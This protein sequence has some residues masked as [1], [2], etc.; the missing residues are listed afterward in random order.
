M[1]KKIR[2]IIE[3]D[4]EKCTGCGQCIIA[5]AEGALAIVDGKARLVGEIY[6][7]GLGACI[8]SCPEDAL[9]IVER[10]AE[11]FDENAVEELKRSSQPQQMACGCPSSMT[12]TLTPA[13]SPTS[14]PH[15]STLGHWPVKLALL[16]P[17]APFLQ[18]ADLVLLADC[19]AAAYPGLH[20]DILPGRAIAMACPK[21]D[22]LE[23]HIERLAA[24]L[25]EARP[26]SL[27]IV[28]ME[29]PCCSGL[30][31][32]AN[33]AMTRAGVELPVEIIRIGIDGKV[34]ETSHQGPVSAPGACPSCG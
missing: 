2:K 23:P 21:L 32:A 12:R 9:R 19:A 20:A 30:I 6:C 8:G 16:T 5:C 14:S 27:K 1:P 31:F 10:E 24:I 7:D 4:E 18:G 22:E 17:A 3:I 11:E 33:Q 26:A 25:A 34:Q 29:V 13:A 28:H 15:A